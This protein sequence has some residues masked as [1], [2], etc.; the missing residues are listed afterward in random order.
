MA[1]G[2]SSSGSGRSI[3][4]GNA[5]V[6]TSVD[7]SGLK[8][9][10]KKAER[11]VRKFGA[12]VAAGG[13]ALIGFGG[14]LLAPILESFREVVKEFDEIKKASDRLGSSAEVVSALGYA[15][16]NSG[17]DFDTFESSARHLQK[18]IIDA[19]NGSQEA[20]LALKALGLSAKDLQS[21]SL[22]E[23]FGL[24]ADG[25]AGIAAEE[26][27]PALMAV[28]GKSAA[29]LIPML[30]N[31]SAGLKAMRAEAEKVGAIVSSEDAENAE[32]AGDAIS[33]AWNAVKNT[34]RS[35]GAALLPQVDSIER[36]SSAFVDGIKYIRDFVN[37]NRQVILIVTAVAA[38]LI[39]AG[40]ALLAIGTGL[41][42]ASIAVSGFTAVI[43]GLIAAAPVI[44]I[45][46]A[47]GL[48]I[49][50]IGTIAVAVAAQFDE[51][52]QALD[53]G[54][55]VF[56]TIWGGIAATFQ[57]T[58]K[59]ISD[60][61][62]A[63]DLKLAF[64]IGL[65]ELDVLWQGFLLGLQVAWNEFKGMFVDGWHDTVTRIELAWND[66]GSAITDAMLSVLQLLA[67]QFS[68]FFTRFLGRAAALAERVGADDL[69]N[70][71]KAIGEAGPGV[72]AEARKDVERERRD[73]EKQIK[74]EADRAQAERNAA[75]NLDLLGQAA[76]LAAAQVNLDTLVKKAEAEKNA[77][78]AGNLAMLG[79]AIVLGQDKQRAA[80][81]AGMAAASKGTFST[82]GAGAQMFGGGAGIT[83]DKIQRN[84]K[85]AADDLGV[86]KGKVGPAKWS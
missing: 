4:A 68:E 18:T 70:D 52:W 77:K 73:K 72:F 15:A 27:A 29:A 57:K 25:L 51:F 82:F 31:G 23:Q 5:H 47:I 34:F 55:Y 66:L 60:A 44:L 50:T 37:E 69:A 74:E 83:L 58:W 48:A 24:I 53:A 21:K 79:L 7:D 12:G 36:F 16:A 33:R 6:T 61:L 65:A 84:T 17:S 9:G 81:I 35:V 30:K 45:V 67:E 13:G 14:A 64:Q 63:G 10:L 38:G 22:D 56:D 19:A 78:I 8:S 39:A 62:A 46:T 11:M 86:I 3:K 80:A 2:G 85:D 20:Q 76:A 26:R 42:A 1:V 75:R 32:R 28:M 54:A 41:F 49:A 43:S 40:S 59:G 71:L